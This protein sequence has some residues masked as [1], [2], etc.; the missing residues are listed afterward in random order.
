MKLSFRNPSPVS[1][2][3]GF[4]SVALAGQAHAVYTGLSVERHAEVSF[5]GQDWWVYRVYANFTD[6]ADRLIEGYGSPTQGSAVIESRNSTD[7]GP[8]GNFFNTPGGTLAPTQ[9][10]INNNP[11]AQWDSFF[12]IGVSIADQGDPFDMTLVTPQFT[13]LSGNSLTI[14]NGAWYVVPTWDHD[15]NPGTDP[16]APPQTIAGYAGDGDLQNRVM[17]LQLTVAAGENVRGTMNV[18][19]FQP[20]PGGSNPF[21]LGQTFNSIP[22]PAALALVAI[23]AAFR[24]RRRD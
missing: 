5:N 22:G 9:D 24:N 16:I 11:L 21:H 6:P 23:A 13:P 17:M 2:A 18:I 8:G 1:V 20:Y 14:T 15:N 12:T 4:L 7:T 10:I 19:T 3:A